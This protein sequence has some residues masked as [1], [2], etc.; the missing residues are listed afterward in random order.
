M[1]KQFFIFLL[2]EGLVSRDMKLIVFNGWA[3]F[4]LTFH[5]HKIRV[6]YRFCQFYKNFASSLFSFSKFLKTSLIGKGIRR[7]I[8]NNNPKSLKIA[9]F[10]KIFWAGTCFGTYSEFKFFVSK[11][12]LKTKQA[13]FRA[14]YT[15]HS[16]LDSTN[17]NIDFI[18]ETSYNFY[19]NWVL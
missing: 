1:P 12:D 3:L 5:I 11:V 10:F 13:Q 18:P 17:S 7:D 19:T 9:I 14:K 4:M 2:W 16:S 6:Y 15:I 8:Q